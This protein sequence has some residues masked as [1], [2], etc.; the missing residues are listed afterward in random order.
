MESKPRQFI[1]GGVDVTDKLTHASFFKLRGAMKVVRD[2]DVP[3]DLKKSDK[4]WKGRPE[5][6]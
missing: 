2:D 3:E 5:S 1:L 4:Y 6:T